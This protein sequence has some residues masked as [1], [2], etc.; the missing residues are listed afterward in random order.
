MSEWE[1]LLQVTGRLNIHKSFL[2]T[3]LAKKECIRAVVSCGIS[4]KQTDVEAAVLFI[5]KNTSHTTEIK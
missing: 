5:R 4:R 2:E 3:W 1:R